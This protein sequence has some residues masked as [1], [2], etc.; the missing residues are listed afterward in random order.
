MG[1]ARRGRK[2]L[3]RGNGSG[4][5]R[6]GSDC[7]TPLARLTPLPSPPGWVLPALFQPSRPHLASA[8]PLFPLHP[9]FPPAWLEAA[10]CSSRAL[11]TQRDCHDH[12]QAPEVTGL[13]GTRNPVM[14]P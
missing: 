9:D 11:N 8:R 12:H 5:E 2:K 6:G 10:V 4:E 1:N 7:A 13:V 14:N 3:R